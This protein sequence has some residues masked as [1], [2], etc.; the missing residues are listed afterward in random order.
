MHTDPN[1]Q[2]DTAIIAE[3][4][5][6]GLDIEAERCD[7][8]AVRHTVEILRDMSEPY[9]TAAVALANQGFPVRLSDEWGAS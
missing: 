4:L 7:I 9:R 2:A 6:Y 8:E 1:D 3:G 5:G